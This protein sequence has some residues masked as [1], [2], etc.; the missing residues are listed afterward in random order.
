MYVDT[1]ATWGS[2]DPETTEM[3]PASPPQPSPLMRPSR[4]FPGMRS[5]AWRRE[6]GPALTG[7]KG[8]RSRSMIDY[9]R[10]GSR[11]LGSIP[12]LVK[13]RSVFAKWGVGSIV[14]GPW[15]VDEREYPGSV[16]L[17]APCVMF[18]AQ[19]FSE[20]AVVRKDPP[21]WHARVRGRGRPGD[22]HTVQGPRELKMTLP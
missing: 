17:G 19:S 15:D 6:L 12:C 18:L 5:E 13:S 3:V 16:K 1:P 4:D 2:L 21:R 10:G 8:T 22:I 11:C 14:R 20:N 7:H 9:R